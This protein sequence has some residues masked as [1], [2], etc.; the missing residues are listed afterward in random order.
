MATRTSVFAIVPA[1][2][3]SAATGPTF[4]DN[5]ISSPFDGH[6]GTLVVTTAPADSGVVGRTSHTPGACPSGVTETTSW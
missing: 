5:E 6:E 1:A 2:V 3:A 4:A